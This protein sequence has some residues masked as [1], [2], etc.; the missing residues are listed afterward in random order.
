MQRLRALL[1]A[2]AMTVATVASIPALAA[3]AHA[4]PGD[5]S[6][7]HDADDGYDAAFRMRCPNYNVYWIYEGAGSQSIT[8]MH[9]AGTAIYVAAGDEIVCRTWYGWGTRWDATG[10]A[11]VDL[12]E[13]AVCVHQR[14]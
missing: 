3:P 9:G 14:D 13:H 11:A 6:V 7:W 12:H 8:C 4:T 5:R 2:I 10:W 1:V